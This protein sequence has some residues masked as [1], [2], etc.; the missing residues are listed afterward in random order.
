MTKRL[1]DDGL[2]LEFEATVKSVRKEDDEYWVL[3]DRTAFA[4]DGGGQLSD[5]GSIDGVAVLDVAPDDGE[6][7]HICDGE[8]EVG[9]SVHCKIDF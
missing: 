7:Y 5:I 4:P 8:L 1:F 3:L 2:L 9:A 6:I